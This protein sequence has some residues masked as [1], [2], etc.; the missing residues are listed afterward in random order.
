MLAFVKCRQTFF[1]KSLACVSLRY[2]HNE[3]EEWRDIPGFSR[4]Q[5][6]S[7]GNFKNKKSRKLL[8][9]NYDRMR[10][11]KRSAQICLMNDLG[12]PKNV[13]I[14]RLILSTFHPLQNN[15]KL[16]AVHINGD[17]FDNRLSNLEWNKCCR[18]HHKFTNG[19]ET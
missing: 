9:I 1:S 18:A 17:K 3:I 16:L 19:N 11:S 10:N 7:F 2:C 12:K 15:E 14:A 5:L 13:A 4:Y 8:K 6:S